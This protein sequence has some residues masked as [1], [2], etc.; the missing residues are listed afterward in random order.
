MMMV[1]MVMMHHC[2]LLLDC[3]G[4]R[5]IFTCKVI[6]TV[7]EISSVKV[8]TGF[9]HGLLLIVRLVNWL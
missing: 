9:V 5:C 1:V 4:R 2:E 3:R 7:C 8:V 6:L